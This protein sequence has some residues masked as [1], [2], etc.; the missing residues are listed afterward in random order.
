MQRF[1]CCWP[2]RSWN[3]FGGDIDEQ[4]ILQTIEAMARLRPY[5]YEY[6]N[7][8]DNWQSMQRAANGSLL[9]NEL[10]FPHGIAHLAELAHAR[11]LKLGIYSARGNQTCQGRPGSLGHYEIDAAS[12]A[13]W[14]VD[15]LKLD[16]CGGNGPYGSLSMVEQYAMMRD[17]LKV[18][19]TVRPIYY[20]IC[21]YI[22]LSPHLST[23]MA[24][25]SCCGCKAGASECGP[26]LHPDQPCSG[27]YTLTNYM[28]NESGPALNPA[29]PVDALAN[30][31]LVEWKNNAN[32]FKREHPAGSL[33]VHGRP[34][35]LGYCEGWLTNFDAAQ[36]LTYS[37]LS[38]PG[39]WNDFDML[40]VGCNNATGNSTGHGEQCQ[41]H[42]TMTEQRAQF[43]LWCMLS[44]PLILGHDI[45]YMDEDIFKIITNRDLILLQQD[46]VGHQA[47]VV[48]QT[49]GTR[50]QQVLFKRLNLTASPRAVAL[51]N[52]D[53][54]TATIALQRT[55]LQMSSS[56]QCACVRLVDLEMKAVVVA[57]HCGAGG[58]VYSPSVLAHQALVLRVYCVGSS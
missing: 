1:P 7:I 47:E 56:G 5:G 4:K 26:P 9:P 40:T 14:G 52:R 31:V 11:S 28:A 23:A 29:Y 30:S 46:T 35:K 21:P 27:A 36:D 19:S 57:K 54:S 10:K 42:Q 32:Y 33:V 24:S 48:R 17:A 34:N 39:H 38:G 49:P 58:V 51:F 25:P 22:G 44:S 6:V 13:A 50:A 18:Y 8:D 16:S 3:V 2:A 12:F 55:D 43:A 53:E 45:R 20:S 37:Y 15:Y 41:G